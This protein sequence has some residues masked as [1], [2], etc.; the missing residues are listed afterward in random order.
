MGI[1][2]CEL[3]DFNKHPHTWAVDV[4]TERLIVRFAADSDRRKWTDVFDETGKKLGH[5]SHDPILALPFTA[6]IKWFPVLGAIR[7]F[8]TEEET[9]LWMAEQIAQAQ[10]RQRAVD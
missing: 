6:Y 10:E 1:R 8:R 4:M 9:R 2:I 7:R 5:Y 3:L